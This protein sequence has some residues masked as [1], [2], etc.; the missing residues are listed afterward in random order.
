MSPISHSTRGA[1]LHPRLTW[2]LA[3]TAITVL[4]ALLQRTPLAPLPHSA[5]GFVGGLAVGLAASAV[6]GWLMSRD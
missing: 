6:V 1:A 5:D 3:L 4:A 2:L